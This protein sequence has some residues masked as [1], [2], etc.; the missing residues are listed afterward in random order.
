MSVL[1]ITQ[2]LLFVG[3]W[4]PVNRFNHSSWIEVVTPIGRPFSLRNQC[5]IEF[6]VATLFCPLTFLFS[7]CI[8]D[9]AIGLSQ[10]PFFLSVY[11]II[12]CRYTI[13]LKLTTPYPGL[14]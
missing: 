1:L 5:V 8:G 6:V 2:L 4:D 14:R 3:G 10:F 11:R 7:D 9:F 12:Y 13:L